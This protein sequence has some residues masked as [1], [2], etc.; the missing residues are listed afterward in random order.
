M[1]SGPSDRR[2]YR[3]QLEP[4]SLIEQ[5]SAHPPEGF[6]LLNADGLQHDVPVFAA[7]FDLLTSAEDA[8]KKRVLASRFSRFLGRLL[9]VRTAFVGTTVSEYALLP[10]QADIEALP[11][12]WLEAWGRHHALLIVKDLPQQSP[13]LSADDN[14]VSERLAAACSAAGFVLLQGQA[15]A[16]VPIDFDDLDGYFAR[17]PVG[18]RKNLRRKMRSL[19]RL[20]VRRVPT[21]DPHFRDPQVIDVYYALYLAVYAQSEVHFDKLTR[22][23][24]AAVLQDAGSRGIVFEYRPREAADQ[25]LIGWNL[26]FES[27]G[28]LV[29]KYIGLAYPAAREHDLYFVSWVV[30]LDYAVERGLR[31]YVA[32]WTDPVVKARLGASFTFTR[33]AVF[34][35]NPLLRSLA[36]RLFGRFEGDRLRLEALR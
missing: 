25:A 29:D 22:A 1:S 9:K 28:M 35:R 20:E 18:R 31:Y 26:C 7:C 17:L 32:G 15:L 14:A 13:L 12:N 21:G 16:Y 8:W 11:T 33:H 10:V 23:F 24:F 2:R 34:V 3:N 6:A 27:S 4:A 19:A 30:N 36:R 5:F